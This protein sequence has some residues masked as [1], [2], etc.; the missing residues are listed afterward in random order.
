MECCTRAGE[1]AKARE[2]LV[3]M[4]TAGVAKNIVRAAHIRVCTPAEPER[5]LHEHMW[6]Y[7]VR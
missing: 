7:T 1:M 3:K 4:G 6:S 5:G 2:V